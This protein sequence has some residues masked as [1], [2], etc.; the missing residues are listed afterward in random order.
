MLNMLMHIA[1]TEVVSDATDIWKLMFTS[2]HPDD[3][4]VYTCEA[5]NDLDTAVGKITLSRWSC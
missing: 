5:S 3:L 4:G 1:V 2:L